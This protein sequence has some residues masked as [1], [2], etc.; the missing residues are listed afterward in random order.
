[1]DL[2]VPLSPTLP[3]QI[4]PPPCPR[5]RA[6]SPNAGATSQAGTSKRCVQMME[7]D[8]CADRSSTGGI[9]LSSPD[10]DA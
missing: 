3:P 9:Y 5:S 1:M 6:G 4:P 7:M 2:G 10:A 8:S